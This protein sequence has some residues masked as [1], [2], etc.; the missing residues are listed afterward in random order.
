MRQIGK[1][2]LALNK[3]A[4]KTAEKI[5]TIESK[6]AKWIA[7]DAIRELKSESVQKRLRK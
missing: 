7:A 2:N 5:K 4:I 6:A 1:R 3:K